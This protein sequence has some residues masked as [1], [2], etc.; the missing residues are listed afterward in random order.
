MLLDLGGSRPVDVR[1]ERAVA[2]AVGA[3]LA[4]HGRANVLV[5]NAGIYPHVPFHELGLE[6]WREVLATRRGGVPAGVAVRVG[7]DVVAAAIISCTA[8]GALWD[9]PINQDAAD[10]IEAQQRRL[11][12]RFPDTKL[13]NLAPPPR[14]NCK[15]DGA[16]AG[17]LHAQLPR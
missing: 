15:P 5:N 3:V 7:D 2:V 13:G 4:E 12:A 11:Q 17:D 14:L 1:D 8:G 10:L 9:R 6:G 16:A